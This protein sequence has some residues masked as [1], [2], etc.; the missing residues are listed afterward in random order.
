MS[1]QNFEKLRDNSEIVK[2]L[3]SKK[4]QK[5]ITLIT[6]SENPIETLEHMIQNNKHFE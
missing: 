6:E 2:L 3:S 4:L 1:Q 5:D